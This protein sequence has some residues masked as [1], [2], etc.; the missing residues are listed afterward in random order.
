MTRVSTAL[1]GFCSALALGTFGAK[2]TTY[3]FIETSCASMNGGCP[4]GPNG[5]DVPSLPAVIATFS[6]PD[7]TG[8]YQFDSIGS[9]PPFESGDTDFS[10]Q[11]AGTG[12]A[13]VSAGGCPDVEQRGCEWNI[14]WGGGPN[15]V[16]FYQPFFSANINV[17]GNGIGSDAEMAG[18]G[19]FAQCQITGSWVMVAEASSV[20]LLGVAVGFFALIVGVAARH[21]A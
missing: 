15:Q 6:S 13:P 14:T 9:D 19:F 3:N 2:A 20:T 12:D 8:Q 7:A 10:L 4:G 21:E 11:W 16:E 18:C 17:F 1:L 5:F